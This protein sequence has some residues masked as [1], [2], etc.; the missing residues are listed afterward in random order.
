[1]SGK[2]KGPEYDAECRSLLHQYQM[3]SQSVQNF[4]GLNHFMHVRF[5]LLL[6]NLVSRSISSSSVSLPRRGS[7]K[8]EAATKEKMLTRVSYVLFFKSVNLGS[9]SV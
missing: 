3:S 7:R 6:V 9:K 8:E 5:V 4:P 2:V 1:M